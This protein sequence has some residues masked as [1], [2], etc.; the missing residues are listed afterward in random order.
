MVL[1]SNTYLLTILS[2]QITVASAHSIFIHGDLHQWEDFH[3]KYFSQFR[4]TMKRIKGLDNEIKAN[5]L[6]DAQSNLNYFLNIVK[7]NK[8]DA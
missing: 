7:P 1:A 3:Y 2:V 8:P 6:M 5:Q 4:Q